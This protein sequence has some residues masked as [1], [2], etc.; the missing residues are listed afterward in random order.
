MLTEAARPVALQRRHTLTKEGEEIGQFELTLACSDAG[1]SYKVAYAETR[2]A[3]DD[4]S[5]AG[6]Q[7]VTLLLGGQRVSLTV[8]SSARR[9]A[10][11][12]AS[13]AS[14]TVAPDFIDQL[15][16]NPESVII[17]ATRTEDNVRTSIRVGSTGFGK[18]FSRFATDCAK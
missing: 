14:G 17:V 15:R 4:A 10:A 12:L 11:E 5:L 3:A 18:A 6:L 16:K 7:A 9:E 8:D 13:V 2:V 1:K